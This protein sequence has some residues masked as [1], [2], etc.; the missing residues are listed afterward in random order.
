MSPICENIF[1]A[2]DIRGLY[3]KEINEETYKLL[4]NS[5]G[6]KISSTN[7]NKVIV[8][9][10]G[11]I[12]SSSLKKNLIL[13]LIE[14]GIDVIDIGMLP[15][16]LMYYSLGLLNISNGLMITG[17]H[18]PKDYNGIKMV[19]DGTTL[20]EEHIQEIKHNIINDNILLSDKKGVVEINNTI[21][22][23]YTKSLQNNLKI[24][25]KLNVTIDCSNGVTGIIV[26]KIFNSFGIKTYII[27]EDIDGNFPNHSPDP[28]N[29]NNLEQL[30][31]Y[32]I[33]NNSDVGIAY[34]G[35]GDRV[36]IIDKDTNIIWPD[37]LLM[38]F[39]YDILQ[40]NP[41][42]KIVYDIKCSQHLEKIISQ[43][44][45]I[46]I[47]SRTGHSFIKKTMKHENAK[48]GGEMS[49]HIFFA[50]KWPGFDDGVYSSL[51]FLE[52]LSKHDCMI[53][54]LQDIPKSITTPEINI[55]FEDNKHFNFM[56]LF[57]KLAKFDDAK[58]IDID[59]IK[60]IYDFGWGLIRCSNTTSNIVLRFEAKNSE[61]MMKIQSMMKENMLKID[62][63]LKIPF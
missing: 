32:V 28:T 19:I 3:P 41:G 38:Y 46:P 30:K 36:I 54:A 15:T 58:I 50:D 5:I 42:V 18:N 51:R 20:F 24:S 12:S 59:G 39:S 14:V 63:T 43:N 9:M 26:K 13:G 37:Q 17:S 27:N 34:D 56:K 10:D 31:K 40:N 47:L 48:L 21:A 53:E 44:N 4:G 11:R 25:N 1:R 8:C 60:V 33:K 6:T 7:T 2:Y 62:K 16:P 23:E 52:I 29:T 61:S 45:G 22:E 49:G 55:P 57:V 35:D